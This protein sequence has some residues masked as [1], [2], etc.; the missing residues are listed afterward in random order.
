ME[1]R[2]SYSTLQRPKC[3][4][5]PAPGPAT[6]SAS[7]NSVGSGDPLGSSG[8]LLE[9]GAAAPAA[10][11]AVPVPPPRKCQSEHIPTKARRRCRALYDCCADQQDEL[12]FSEGEIIVII[13]E[14]TEDDHENASPAV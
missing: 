1:E 5:P 12:S 9:V 2:P 3:P 11:T 4:P 7:C 14:I 13:S 10:T 6:S 8:Y